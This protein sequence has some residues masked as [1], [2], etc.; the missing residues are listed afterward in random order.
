MAKA[1]AAPDTEDIEIV[2]ADEQETAIPDESAPATEDNTADE[3][4]TAGDDDSAAE[5]P[6]EPVVEVADVAREEGEPLLLAE[7]PGFHP[8]TLVT[9]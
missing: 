8:E 4:P 2:A 6:A 1:T 9:P 5:G 3:A 7:H